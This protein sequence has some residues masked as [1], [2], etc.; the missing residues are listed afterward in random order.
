MFRKADERLPSITVGRPRSNRDDRVHE[1][2]NSAPSRCG[3]GSP[4]RNRSV[5]A[6][7]FIW[8]MAGCA[9]VARPAFK[10][11]GDPKN[12]IDRTG[13]APGRRGTS[14]TAMPGALRS[15]GIMP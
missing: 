5:Y 13:A 8:V 3:I 15:I 7:E 4:L 9:P 14:E 12:S 10:I 11:G 1:A 6:H 2:D